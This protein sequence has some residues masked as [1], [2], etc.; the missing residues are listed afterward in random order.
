MPQQADSQYASNPHRRDDSLMSFR[1]YSTSAA[2]AEVFFRR[3]MGRRY[4]NLRVMGGGL[5]GLTIA[6]LLIVFLEH[7]PTRMIDGIQTI[8]FFD[9]FI[10]LFILVSLGHFIGYARRESRGIYIH[11]WYMGD[12]R[13]FFLL[14]ALGIRNYRSLTYRYVEPFMLLL[15]VPFALFY[16]VL[17]GLL[18]FFAVFRLG[19][20][21][22]KLLARSHQEDLDMQ[23]G[24]LE[25]EEISER[26]KGSAAR[27]RP[28]RR[29]AP[30]KQ[31]R[32]ITRQPT[33]SKPK[34]SKTSVDEALRRLNPKLRNLGEDDKT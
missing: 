26:M 23:D 20:E 4:Y 32:R 1:R 9:A 27:Q 17:L 24:R 28:R 12:S 16:S 5:I 7:P 2:I 30:K 15:V 34:E 22:A 29:K 13:F 25:A 6:R 14:R 11:S 8:H 18:V 19:Y 33:S 3:R 21:N 31:P 10:G